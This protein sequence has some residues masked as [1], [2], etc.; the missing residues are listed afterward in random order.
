MQRT[1]RNRTARYQLA[2]LTRDSSSAGVDSGLGG[3]NCLWQRGLS[4][5]LFGNL[6]RCLPRKLEFLV[7]L[8]GNP[9]GLWENSEFSAKGNR[10]SH[11]GL[12]FQRSERGGGR[13][14]DRLRERSNKI[15]FLE[16]RM[17]ISACKQAQ[18]SWRQMCWGTSPLMCAWGSPYGFLGMVG[19]PQGK[20]RLCGGFIH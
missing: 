11:L 3:S 18:S 1:L 6:I 13:E 19:A 2:R 16:W 14:G 5:S 10:K 20:N 15:R 17:S 9:T 12:G 4:L 8:T 7:S